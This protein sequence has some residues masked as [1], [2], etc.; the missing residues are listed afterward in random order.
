MVHAIGKVLIPPT[1]TIA[2]I[3][4]GSGTGAAGFSLLLDAVVRAG[5]GLPSGTPSLATLLSSPGK[6]TVFAPTNAAFQATASGA[7]INVSTTALI[8]ALPVTA[9]AGVLGSHAYSTNIFAGDLVAGVVTSPSTLNPAT[10][11]TF[12]LST[13]ATVKITGTATTA[14]ITTTDIVAT[15]GVIHII[16]KV[17]Q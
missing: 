9:V 2:Q 4:S 12:A 17:L 14:G 13:S 7:A 10:T 11:L 15:N 1:Q 8:N 3:V 16:D 6:Y 5:V